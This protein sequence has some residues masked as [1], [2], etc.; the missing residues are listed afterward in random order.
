MSEHSPSI[1][2]I[3]S[4]LMTLL[5][6]RPTSMTSLELSQMRAYC[7]VMADYAERSLRSAARRDITTITGIPFQW[8]P[9][10]GA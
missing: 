7:Q 6:K 10:T 8:D 9:P 2:L 4:Q 5:L 1:E 3:G